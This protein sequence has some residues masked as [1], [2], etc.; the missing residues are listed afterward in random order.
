MQ[1][2]G[3]EVSPGKLFGHRMLAI[4]DHL[5]LLKDEVGW[6]FSL[7]NSQWYKIDLGQSVPADA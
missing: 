1:I 7:A 4:S 2:K 5:V 6:V 3:S